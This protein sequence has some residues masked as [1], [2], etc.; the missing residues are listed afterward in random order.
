[1]SKYF[2]GIPATDVKTKSNVNPNDLH[3]TLKY[4][5][6]KTDSEL[7]M[8]IPKLSK[9][10]DK[11]FTLVT[12]GYGRFNGKFPHLNIKE[13]KRLFKLKEDVWKQ[14]GPDNRSYKPH[15]TLSYKNVKRLPNY[16]KSKINVN[17]YVLYKINENLQNN[18]FIPVKE[19]PLVK[20]NIFEKGIDWVRDLF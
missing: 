7:S 10:K 20:R 5:D 13:N 4:L 9:I 17:K 15:I 1:M 3:I 6:N 16:R 14:V 11:D 2:L 12:D 19:F 8:L 18:R